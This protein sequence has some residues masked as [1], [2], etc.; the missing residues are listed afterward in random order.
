LFDWINHDGINLPM[1]NSVVRNRFYDKLLSRYVQDQDCVEIGFGTGLL[2][3]IALKHGAKSIIAYEKDQARFELGQYVISN[4]DLQD[5]IIIKNKEFSFDDF[6]DQPSAKVFFS[7]IVSSYLFGEGLWNVIPRKK[8]NDRIF[9]PNRY[10]LEVWGCEVPDSVARGI[11]KNLYKFKDVFGFNP[12]I[13]IDNQFIDIIN[14][15]LNKTYYANNDQEKIPLYDTSTIPS[16]LREVKIEN[17]NDWGNYVFWKQWATKYGKTLASFEL[18]TN[19]HSI[20]QK[21]K[22]SEEGKTSE[23]DHS[24]EGYQ[25]TI[26]MS[27]NHEKN[28][29]LWPRISFGD[30]Q[31][32]LYLDEANCWIFI[33]PLLATSRYSKDIIVKHSFLDSSFEI[34]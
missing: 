6:D 16:E 3:I 12:G 26:D 31:D 11:D 23:I 20:F 19:N 4:L 21:D 9:I 8:W 17:T 24:A 1:I 33:P 10:Q 29:L 30:D 32:K 22:F 34:V 5:K 13:D 18:D 7:E 28:I 15:L 25:L 27:K 14:D 2:S